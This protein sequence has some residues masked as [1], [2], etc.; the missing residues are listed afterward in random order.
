MTDWKAV[1]KGLLLGAGYSVMVLYDEKILSSELWF[2]AGVA[3]FVGGGLWFLWDLCR[4]ARNTIRAIEEQTARELEM[5]R[6][7]GFPH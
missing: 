6:Q 2:L 7:S 4:D 5:M 1:T 3:A